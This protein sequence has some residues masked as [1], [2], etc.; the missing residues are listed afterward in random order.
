M[1][2]RIIIALAALMVSPAQSAPL[3]FA[4]VASIVYADTKVAFAGMRANAYIPNASLIETIGEFI[5][6][7]GDE[8]PALFGH[9]AMIDGC[10]RHSCIE[11]AA[12]VVDMRS[13]TIAAVALRNYE[14]RHVVLDDSDIAAMARS[15][16]KR[17][18]ARCNDEP[19]LDIYVVRRSIK[20]EALRDER[21]QLA[22]LRKWGNNVGHQ[23]ERVQVL[24]RHKS[25]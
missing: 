23:G 19:I 22:Q 1:I 20:P 3:R 25:R 13:R 2:R 8:T 11:K 6:I 18:T 9:Y 24:V 10:R 4:D 5:G 12:I 21:E 17:P 15:S 14:C 7:P 16:S